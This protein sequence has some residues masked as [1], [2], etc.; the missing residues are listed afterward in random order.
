[1]KKFHGE[2]VA[3]KENQDTKFDK[4]VFI[5]AD[6]K[7]TRLD[8]KVGLDA[9]KATLAVH[10]EMLRKVNERLKD[11]EKANSDKAEVARA[12]FEDTLA[13][14]RAEH[15]AKI[16]DLKA[17]EGKSAS[18][19]K[20]LAAKLCHRCGNFVTD[21]IHHTFSSKKVLRTKDPNVGTELTNLKTPAKS[22]AKPSAKFS[23]KSLAKFASKSPAIDAA[24]ANKEN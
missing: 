4:I 8:L 1:M 15:E 11:L 14:V 2:V 22:P 21:M 20:E 17:K 5:E 6:I 10:D 16:E 24:D 12:E 13:N 19:A 7:A 18:T 9:I 23:A 3:L